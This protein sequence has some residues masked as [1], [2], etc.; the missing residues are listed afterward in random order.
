MVLPPSNLEWY[1]ARD[2]KQYGPLS[3]LELLKF[4]D[5]GHLQPS[6]LLWR[7][8]FSE[9]RPATVVFP[10]LLEVPN[11][12]YA[13]PV[14]EPLVAKR[15][16]ERRAT[17]RK[18]LGLALFLIFVLSAAASYSYFRIGWPFSVPSIT[19][20]DERDATSIRLGPGSTDSGKL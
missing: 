7:G 9:W 2:A 3:D 11:P 12:S 19:G 20:P 5:L 6:D 16:L 18:A 1:L 15:P 17:S 13:D 8:G 4:I 10:E 14:S